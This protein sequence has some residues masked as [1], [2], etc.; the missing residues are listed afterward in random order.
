MYRHPVSILVDVLVA[1]VSAAIAVAV[2]LPFSI[3]PPAVCF[4]VVKSTTEHRVRDGRSR[5][6]ACGAI[7]A[8]LAFAAVVAA[9]AAYRP[10]KVAERQL[11]RTVTLPATRTTLAEL[12]FHATFDRRHFPTLTSLTFADR[13]QNV[14]VEWPA[15]QITVRR[16]LEAIESQTRLRHEF[17]HCGNGYTVL[18]GGDCSMGLMIFDP[19]LKRDQDRFDVDAYASRRDAAE[20]GHSRPGDTP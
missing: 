15:R 2:I 6:A 20:C 1:L 7:A 12:A 3:I 11:N 14:V 4:A 5:L 16:F 8:T 9:A 17:S 18:G 19:E 13:D 10:A